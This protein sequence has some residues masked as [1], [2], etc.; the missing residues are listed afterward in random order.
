VITKIVNGHP[1][2]R[3]NELLAWAYPATNRSKRRDREIAGEPEVLRAVR[4]GLIEDEKCTGAGSDASSRFRR[5]ESALLLCG[6]QH[7]GGASSAHHRTESPNSSRSRMTR[8]QAR[9]RTTPW[10]AGIGPSL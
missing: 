5:D 9:Q 7:E 8:S 4:A 1:N 3:I 10:I 2:S 6:R